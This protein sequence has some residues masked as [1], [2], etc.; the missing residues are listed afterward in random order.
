MGISIAF[1]FPARIP[2][3]LEYTDAY[4]SDEVKQGYTEV[5]QKLLVM[6]SD[7]AKTD[8]VLTFTPCNA[9]PKSSG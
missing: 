1:C 4:V 5:V 7:T 9:P 6:G 2:C 8:Q 3:R